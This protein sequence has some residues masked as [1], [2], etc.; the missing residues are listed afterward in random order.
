MTY[1]TFL[2]PRNNT[3]TSHGT[4]SERRQHYIRITAKILRSLCY[5]QIPKIRTA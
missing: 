2:E 4:T 3:G 1:G 5:L